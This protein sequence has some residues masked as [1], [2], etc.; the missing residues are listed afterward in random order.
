MM[1]FLRYFS[2]IP[3]HL[4][5]Y[6]AFKN[7]TTNGDGDQEGTTDRRRSRRF[8]RFD[9][10]FEDIDNEGNCIFNGSRDDNELE[11]INDTESDKVSLWHF[12]GKS[13]KEEKISK[14]EKKRKSR[15][16][17]KR[18]RLKNRMAQSSQSSSTNYI[19]HNIYHSTSDKHIHISGKR[20]NL[21]TSDKRSLYKDIV[22]VQEPPINGYYYNY[23]IDDE[24][25]SQISNKKKNNI[26][27]Y[28]F[29]STHPSTTKIPL[30]MQVTEFGEIK[31]KKINC[32]PKKVKAKQREVN[33]MASKVFDSTARTPESL[34]NGEIIL[35]EKNK[36]SIVWRNICPEN[37]NKINVQSYLIT[38][39][40]GKSFD[41][42][43]KL[44]YMELKDE[45]EN[46]ND[47]LPNEVLLRVFSYLD[48][49]SLCQGAQVC[50]LWN[51]L[52]MNGANWMVVNFFDYQKDIK[53]SVVENISRRSGYFLRKLSLRGCQNIQDGA[54]R[55]FAVNC[56][57]IEAL[58]LGNCKKITDLTCEYLG[59]YCKYL[60]FL[61]FENCLD[62]TD[63]GI[64]AIVNNCTLLEE[65]NFNW[66]KNIQDKGITYLL[67][68][69]KNLRKLLVKGCSGLTENCFERT[70]NDISLRFT[71]LEYLNISNCNTINDNGVMTLSQSLRSLKTLE[72]AGGELL[73]DLS[74]QFVARF[75]KQIKKLD[76]EDCSSLTDNSLY[77]ISKGSFNLE[78][79][80]LSHC[81]GITNNGIKIL[82]EGCTYSL[83]ELELDNLPEINDNV[84]EHLYE[85]KSLRKVCLF[86]CQNIS[87]AAISKFEE[88]RNYETTVQA[89]FAPP[90]PQVV[91]PPPARGICRCC[92][93]L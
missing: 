44:E 2:L 62:I 90:T 83:K 39:M 8:I 45:E 61:D 51:S 77:Y 24:M 93:I 47:I 40:D 41:L 46:I 82:A 31:N 76:I 73:S 35:Q 11:K 70:L 43:K 86:D 80:V 38:S 27:K 32:V 33:G 53:P 49:K 67:S 13:Y 37:Y 63:I 28:L 16:G 65:I 54:L 15:R 71:N 89:Y 75:C 92:T 74:I 59:K 84:F 20:R 87:K 64:M 5:T 48:M 21:P 10:S 34:S 42:K 7:N 50:K 6:F 3:T 56:R 23:I 26:E 4:E 29:T 14:N 85:F 68:K 9:L 18:R 19:L 52:A 57:N 17:K 60:K 79:L 81:E 22:A 12:N 36:N 1:S 88:S 25:N 72:M 30:Q 55:I 78:H 69:C 58:S 66:N 91:D